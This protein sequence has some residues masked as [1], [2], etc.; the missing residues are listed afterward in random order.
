M[1]KRSNADDFADPSPGDTSAKVQIDE[2][3]GLRFLAAF[4]ILFSHSCSWVGRFADSDAISWIGSSIGLFAMPLFFVLS[5]FVIHYNYAKLFTTM[6]PRW[7]LCEF[8]GARLARLYPLFLCALAVGIGVDFILDWLRHHPTNFY[9]FLLHNLTETQSWFYIVF[10]ERLMG[11]YNGFGLGWSISTEIF[12][13]IFYIAIVIPMMTLGVKR[14]ATTAVVFSLAVLVLLVYAEYNRAAFDAFA[15]R[16]FVNAS[17][18]W[19]FSV[20]RWFFYYSPYVRVFE[21]ILG[22]LAAQIFMALGNRV[23]SPREKRLGRAAVVIALCGLAG[24][25][26]IQLTGW[27]GPVVAK[28][29]RFLILNFGL[30]VPIAMLIFCVSRYGTF[31]SG[32]LAGTTMVVLGEMSYS[33]YAVHTWTL[34]IF[35]REQTYGISPLFVA[36][37]VLRIVLAIAVTLLLAAATYRYIEVPSRRGLRKAINNRMVAL[38]GAKDENRLPPGHRHSTDLAVALMIAFLGVLGSCIAYQFIV[39]PLYGFTE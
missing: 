21:F 9:V 32:W 2:L 24:I 14:A 22:C 28:Y 39:V 6:S 25:D 16:N 7:A 26:L 3:H 35:I 38:F 27:P 36:D 10:Y 19:E 33:I 18:K 17:P 37:A 30:A 29:V 12:F 34:R 4:C 11:P 1:P 31:L 13:Y 15:M 5:G 20:H 8:F 23:P